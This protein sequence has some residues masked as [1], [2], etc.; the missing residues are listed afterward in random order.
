MSCANNTVIT[1]TKKKENYRRQRNQ[2][3]KASHIIGLKKK[4][5]ENITN[6]FVVNNGIK[7]RLK[8]YEK[9]RQ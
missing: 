7:S 1:G 2:N 6:D 4:L 9:V 8:K 5:H 3:I